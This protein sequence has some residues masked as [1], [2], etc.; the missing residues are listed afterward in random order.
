MKCHMFDGAPS[1][2][3]VCLAVSL[4]CACSPQEGAGASATTESNASPA[5]VEPAP[6]PA[7]AADPV[8]SPAEGR[9]LAAPWER[10]DAAGATK[11]AASQGPGNVPPAAS[12]ADS[13][14]MRRLEQISAKL[15]TMRANNKPDPVEVEKAIAELESVYGSSVVGGIDLK[16]VRSNLRG[17]SRMQELQKEI[18]QL[19]AAPAETKEAKEA[20][21]AKLAEKYKEI[22]SVVGRMQT[23]TASTG[24]RTKSAGAQ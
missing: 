21:K 4:L 9:T 8:K 22:Q 13:E 6:R 15:Q 20:N 16:A 3:S 11:N 2:I 24:E 18:E 7:S 5:A 23:P 12:A 14:R 17:V 10:S 1:L 19:R